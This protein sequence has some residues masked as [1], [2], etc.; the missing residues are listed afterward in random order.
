[1][2]GIIYTTILLFILPPANKKGGLNP[3][4]FKNFDICPHFFFTLSSGHVVNVLLH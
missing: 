2:I 4:Y 1:M 3:P